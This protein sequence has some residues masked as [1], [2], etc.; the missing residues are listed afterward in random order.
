MAIP[1]G[2]T[3]DISQL[4]AQPDSKL[5]DSIVPDKP[6][7][8][9]STIEYTPRVPVMESMHAALDDATLCMIKAQITDN[10]KELNEVMAEYK[11]LSWDTRPIK[12]ST[13]SWKPQPSTVAL[14]QKTATTSP[15][16]EIKTPTAGIPP[17]PSSSTRFQSRDYQRS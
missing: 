7:R 12:T 16:L 8:D 2:K 5:D 10:T 14:R 15:H 9:L 17:N 11:K 6:M 3:L 13:Y 4:L 1:H